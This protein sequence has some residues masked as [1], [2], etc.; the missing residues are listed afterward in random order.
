MGV[1]DLNDYAPTRNLAQATTLPSRWYTDAAILEA[2]KEKVFG[3]TWQALGHTSRVA[4]PCDYFAADGTGEPIVI[5]RGEENVERAF[6]NVC[7]H[8]ASTIVDGSGNGRI[9]RC[10]YHGW[11]YG[12]DG[13]SIGQPEFEGVQNWDRANACLPGADVDTWGPFVFARLTH[14]GPAL[15]EVLGDIPQRAAAVGCDFA[16][17]QFYA[18]KDYVIKC[19]WKVYIDNYLEGYHVPVAHPGLFRELDYRNYKVETHR[20]H[21]RQLAPL[22]PV[23]GAGAPRR[24]AEVEPDEEV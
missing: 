20:N 16:S 23:T 4:N 3:R 22:R 17:L 9:L 1:M 7:R 5:E 12:L 2:E 11:T 21:S 8:R 19:N 15:A 14:G 10:P 24:Y 18:R 6:S 13:R